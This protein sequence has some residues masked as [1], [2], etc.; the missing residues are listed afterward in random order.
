MV[1]GGN[2]CF[3][4]S[5]RQEQQTPPPK[6]PQQRNQTTHF[7]FETIA[8]ALKEQRGKKKDYAVSLVCP[9]ADRVQSAPSSLPSPPPTTP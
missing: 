4:C 9:M 5:A 8:E 3:S 1:G 6:P 2:R 7:G